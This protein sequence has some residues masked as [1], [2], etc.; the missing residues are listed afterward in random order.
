MSEDFDEGLRRARGHLGRAAMEALEAARTLLETALRANGLHTVAP[1]SLAGEIGR[2]LDALISALREGTPFRLPPALAA[3]LFR[4]LEA[5]ILRWETR[6]KTDPDARP[7]L[8]AF[9]GLREILW[10]FGVRAPGESEP[11]PDARGEETQGTPSDTRPPDQQTK[12]GPARI[13]RFDIEG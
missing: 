4:A 8:R 9:L 6:S 5:E 12:R 13:Q 3:P 2:S 7:V 11:P 1:E 10:E